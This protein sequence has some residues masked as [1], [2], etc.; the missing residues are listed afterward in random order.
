MR[1]CRDRWTIRAGRNLPDKEFRYLRTVIVTAGVHW[2]LGSKLALIPLIFQ[3]WP[4][5]SPYTS[6]YE[7]ARTYVF[8]KQ[9]PL[10]FYCVLHIINYRRKAL[11][12]SYSRCFAEFL[13]DGY[14]DHLSILNPSTCVG[15]RY[16]YVLFLH[17]RFSRKHASSH[18]FL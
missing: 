18:S 15:L 5:F 17:R 12:R 4:G 14:L 2:Y 7:L 10:L 16:G 8:N 1:Q 3:Y 13:K 11:S 9:S 6:S